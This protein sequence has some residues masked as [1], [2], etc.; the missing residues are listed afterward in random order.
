MSYRELTAPRA[1]V[2]ENGTAEPQRPRGLSKRLTGI[3]GS[4]MIG[5]DPFDHK[6]WSGISYQIFSRLRDQGCL[7]RAFGVEVARLRKWL[8]MLR[9]VHPNRSIWRE[10][11]YMSQSYRD[12]LT[13]VVGQR[14]QLD[15]FEHD[16]F[17]LGAVYDVPRLVK[18]R[19]RCFSY[20]DGNLVQCLKSPYAPTGLSVKRIKEGVSFERRVYERTDRILVMSEYL[21]R[22]FVED[23]GIPASRVAVVGAGVN[24]D[25][26]PQVFPDKWYD[27]KQILFIGVDFARKGGPLLLKAFREVR[28]VHRSATLHIVGPAELHLPAELAGGVIH[29]GFLDKSVPSDAARLNELFCACSVFVMPSL[30]EPF[31]IAPLEAMIHQIP[32]VVS[33]AWALEEIVTPGVTGEHVA[34]GSIDDLVERLRTMLA[35]PDLLQRLGVAAR[36]SVLERYT[37]PQVVSRIIAEISAIQE[38]PQ[39]SS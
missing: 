27:T 22:S 5:Y 36:A 23:Y 17:V 15:D 26:I 13:R 18:S 34:P 3:I 25:E 24:L 29:H 21:R 20:H 28:A 11:Y 31:G 14:L 39:P 2:S 9:N 30:Y 35:N 12:S 19:S 33:R 38:Q 6:A 32:A 8:L 1:M 16:F 4:G 7:H 37:W 10:H